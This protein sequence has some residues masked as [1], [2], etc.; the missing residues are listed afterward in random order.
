MIFF[1]TFAVFCFSSMTQMSCSMNDLASRMM[2]SMMMAIGLT[3]AVVTL[4]LATTTVVKANRKTITMMKVCGYN[5]KAARET[6]I[7]GTSN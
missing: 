5:A 3:L 1:I 4:L 2:G 7:T 6:N